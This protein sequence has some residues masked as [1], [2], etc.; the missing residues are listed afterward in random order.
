M[1]IVILGET[2]IGEVILG[3]VLVRL[4]VMMIVIETAT[5]TED[6]HLHAVMMIVVTM[7]GE[8]GSVMEMGTRD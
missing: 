7:D 8:F 3:H 2:V 5:I 1:M 4:V 6:D